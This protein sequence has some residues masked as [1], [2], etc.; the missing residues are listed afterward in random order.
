ME[1]LEFICRSAHIRFHDSEME[2]LPLAEK[3][4]FM[5][6]TL[7]ESCL[8]QVNQV[9]LKETEEEMLSASDDDY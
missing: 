8:H 1:Y 3:V 4:G 5:L 9:R 7:F 2:S 6:E